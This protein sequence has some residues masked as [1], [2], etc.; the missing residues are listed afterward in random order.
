[1]NISAKPY[2][3]MDLEVQ[4]DSKCGRSQDV[5][6]GIASIKT[7]VGFVSKGTTYT[8]PNHVHSLYQ[9][10]CQLEI[11]P[12]QWLENVS[13]TTYAASFPLFEESVLILTEGTQIPLIQK[14]PRGNHP[15]RNPEGEP[16]K[17]MET[18]FPHENELLQNLGCRV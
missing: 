3:S 7:D 12:A 11:L 18:S 2:S 9:D 4:L 17:P 1:M 5:S 13:C 8:F 10:I 6:S 14:N 15:C 16:L